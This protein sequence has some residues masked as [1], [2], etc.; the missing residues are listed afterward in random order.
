MP[1][2]MYR[3]EP[4][5]VHLMPDRR[6]RKFMRAMIYDCVLLKLLF[7]FRSTHV[8][9]HRGYNLELGLSSRR[10]WIAACRS[11]FRS[12]NIQS[13]A[14]RD[15]SKFEPQRISSHPLYLMP[16]QPSETS[17][18]KP[19]TGRGAKQVVGFI[20]RKE[21]KTRT[22]GG[23]YFSSNLAADQQWSSNSTLVVKSCR[24]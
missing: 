6:L 8:A 23:C 19:D 20:T 9:S 17:E 15:Y 2:V 12:V 1:T 18:L 13:L 3:S 22:A 16:W 21:S 7:R 11:L 24:S 5:R 10:S 14:C 4:C